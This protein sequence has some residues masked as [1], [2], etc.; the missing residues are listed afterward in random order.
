MSLIASNKIFYTIRDLNW[1][2][3]RKIYFFKIKEVFMVML[4]WILALIYWPLLFLL[5]V[6]GIINRD[7][8]KEVNL[9][10]VDI[11]YTLRKTWRGDI[12]LHIKCKHCKQR[13]FIYWGIYRQRHLKVFN[14]KTYYIEYCENCK[15]R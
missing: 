13:G 3:K 2:V 6:F 10:I 7:F 11:I 1:Y 9:Y 8:M 5:R 15:G 12:I 14:P 4:W